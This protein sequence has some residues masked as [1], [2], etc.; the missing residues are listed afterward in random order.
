V[1]NGMSPLQ[2]IRAATASAAQVLG[3]E[4]E[5]GRIAPGYLADMIA[6][7]GD[8]LTDITVLERVSAVIKGGKI[9]R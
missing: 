2:A 1:A 7:S 9:F 6:V 3:R 5:L 4:Q 8:P